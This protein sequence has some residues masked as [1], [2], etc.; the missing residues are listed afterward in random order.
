[1]KRESHYKTVELKHKPKPGYRK[2][3][4]IV[5]AILGFYLAYIIFKGV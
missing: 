2:V 1:M 4:Y 3:F 5:L